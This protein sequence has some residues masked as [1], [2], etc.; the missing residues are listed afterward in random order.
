MEVVMEIP[1]HYQVSEYDCV[2]T[3]FINAIA[4]LFD[5]REVPPLVVRHIYAYSLDTVSRGGRLGRAGTSGYAIQLLGHWL[6]HYKTSHFSVRTQFVQGNEV[7]VREN[8]PI[9][10][11]LQEG[12][13][14]LCNLY[15]GQNEWHFILALAVDEEWVT[16][17]DP[18]A[19]KSIRGLGGRVRILSAAS[20]REANLAIRRSHLDREDRSRF[21]LGKRERRECLLLWRVR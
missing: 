3:T 20:G 2:P 13:L 9:V 6:N 15:L 21:T 18:Y 8:G 10:R 17:F 14:A 4:H 5:R 19:R 12:G 7:D 11:A 16:A 1:L